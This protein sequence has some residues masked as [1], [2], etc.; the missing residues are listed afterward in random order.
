MKRIIKY[1]A[2]LLVCFAWSFNAQALTD[3]KDPVQVV[4]RFV[5]GDDMFYVPFDKNA[6]NLDILCNTLKENAAGKG[7]VYV[8]GYSN[9]KQV[10]MIRCNRVKSE[11]I[12]RTGINE[13]TFTTTN[14]VG[15]F[16]GMKNVVVV[17]IVIPEEK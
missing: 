7:S 3:E 14:N 12:I 16:N 2:L 11:L 17:T 13:S 5:N 9:S 1:T 8:D 10:S 6:D 4:F 15:E